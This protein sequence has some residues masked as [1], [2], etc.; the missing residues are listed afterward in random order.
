MKDKRTAFF[1]LE[2]IG[3]ISEETLAGCERVRE[4]RLSRVAAA[5]IA[6]ALV[7]AI[8]LA[9][10]IGWGV[11][12]A[13]P[14][15]G[16]T[17]QIAV[18]TA[19]DTL[20]ERGITADL[21]QASLISNGEE[22][23]YL[24]KLSDGK[25]VYNCSVD[26]HS[27]VVLDIAVEQTPTE[28]RESEAT[29]ATEAAARAATKPTAAPSAAALAQASATS[30]PTRAAKPTQ[31]PAPAEPPTEAPTA[32][33][34]YISPKSFPN[35]RINA[36]NDTGG[37]VVYFS[38]YMGYGFPYKYEEGERYDC[39]AL[40]TSKEQLLEWFEYMAI[41]PYDEFSDVDYLQGQSGDF[42][43]KFGLVGVVRTVGPD[44]SV[45]ITSM[46]KSGS[47]L[48]PIVEVNEG[49]KAPEWENTNVMRLY[50]VDRYFL[51]GVDSVY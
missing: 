27:G 22:P 9:L 47:S 49:A 48:I 21:S 38:E 15:D 19:R 40:L 30:A 36:S 16:V 5:G 51:N 23:Y 1:L 3:E 17:M 8:A 43:D 29:A 26:A 25:G 20:M 35:N 45:R 12:G 41:Y 6:A 24:I 44:G 14:P 2:A 33:P 32:R 7:L 31:P 34:S 50:V 11:P 4:L 37:S 18:D 13:A 39:A 10:I 28:S 46:R 42:F